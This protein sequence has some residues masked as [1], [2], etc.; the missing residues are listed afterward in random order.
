MFVSYQIPDAVIPLRHKKTI[1]K[2]F[3]FQG[4]PGIL[5][6]LAGV[7]PALFFACPS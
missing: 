1:K 2:S 5:A 3:E 6:A 7:L 4:K